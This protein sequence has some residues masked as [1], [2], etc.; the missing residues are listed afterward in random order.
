MAEIKLKGRAE[1][2]GLLDQAEPST[3]AFLGPAGATAAPAVDPKELG[4]ATAPPATGPDP[5]AQQVAES[6][7]WLDDLQA[8]LPIWINDLPDLRARWPGFSFRLTWPK[9]A[10]ALVLE[11][12]PV[13]EV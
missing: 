7:S 13:G 2:A 3:P 4:P 6:P 8:E 12:A 1:S 10:P 11:V 5:K 9:D